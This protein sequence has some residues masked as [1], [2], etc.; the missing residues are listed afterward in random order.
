MIKVHRLNGTEI[1]VNA[2]LIETVEATP[3][4]GI[5][6][7]TGNRFV[8]RESVDEVTEKIVD[9]RKKISAER[10]VVNPIEGFRRE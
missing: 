3:D 8:V 4:T 9:Y 1:T 6:L 7:V 2:E 10:K 5:C